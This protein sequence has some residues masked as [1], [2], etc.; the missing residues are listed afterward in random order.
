MSSFRNKHGL[1]KT[2]SKQHYSRPPRGEDGRHVIVVREVCIQLTTERKRR[3]ALIEGPI[4]RC[5]FT[6]RCV[7]R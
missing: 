5:T 7:V 2:Q 4:R 6:N 3:V 1:R